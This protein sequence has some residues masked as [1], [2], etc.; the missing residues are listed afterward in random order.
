MRYKFTFYYPPTTSDTHPT[1]IAR[2][3]DAESEREAILKL[4]LTI[5]ELSHVQSVEKQNAEL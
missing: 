3:V 1:I 2:Y 4:E 5:E